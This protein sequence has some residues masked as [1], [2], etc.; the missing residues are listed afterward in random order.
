MRQAAYTKVNNNCIEFMSIT[1]IDEHILIKFDQ[2]GWL[3]SGIRITFW[4]FN[5]SDDKGNKGSKDNKA[6]VQ[7]MKPENVLHGLFMHALMEI[8]TIMIYRFHWECKFS[9]REHMRKYMEENIENLIKLVGKRQSYLNEPK[10]KMEKKNCKLWEYS[11]KTT[12]KN[13]RKKK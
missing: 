9:A 7:T 5:I 13:E 12:C 8:H 11:M 3:N 4:I 2:F 10:W 6:K 1:I